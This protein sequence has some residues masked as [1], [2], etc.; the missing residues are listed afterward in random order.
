MLLATCWTALPGATSARAEDP[1]TLTAS[2]WITDRAHALGD[3][4]PEV[5][6]ALDRLHEDRLVQLFAV[7]VDDFSGR[8]A[9]NWADTTA[10]QNGL[11][12][13][14]VLL[15]VATGTRQYAYSVDQDFRL[16][17]QVLG[18]VARESAEPALR[19]GDWAGAAIGTAEGLDTALAEPGRRDGSVSASD[20]VLPVAV[21][22]AAGAVGAY[23]YAR[24]K[25]RSATRTT[26]A[27]TQGAGAQGAGRDGA[28]PQD[29]DA[30]EAEAD[31]TLVAT[32]DAIR[33]S[34]EELG[35][36]VAQ[37]GETATRPFA[38]AVAYAGSELATAFRLRQQL[39]DDPPPEGLALPEG[40]APPDEPELPEEGGE[41]RRRMLWE[42]ISRCAE[43]GRRLD[44]ESEAFDA[45]RALERDTPRALQA[46]E[47]AF[48]TLT[49][50]TAAADSTLTA[51]RQRYADSA[52]APVSGHV[53][54]AKEHLVSATASLNAAHQ[55]VDAEDRGEA[56]AQLRAAETAVTRATTLVDAVDRRAHELTAAVERLP[57]AVAATEALLTEAGATP[58][59]A[60]T[61]ATDTALPPPHPPSA[62]S[63]PAW[64]SRTRCRPRPSRPRRSCR[65]SRT[66]L[67]SAARASRSASASAPTRPASRAS[68]PS[69]TSRTRWT[70]APDVPASQSAGTDLDSEARTRL[71]G[72]LQ[73]A[74]TGGRTVVVGARVLDVDHDVAAAEGDLGGDGAAEIPAEAQIRLVTD[75]PQ[76]LD[77]VPLPAQLLVPGGPEALLRPGH[78]GTEGEHVDPWAGPRRTLLLRR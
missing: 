49:G 2:G 73:D 76:R 40:P 3:R 51:L 53:E 5:A 7:Y 59:G 32:D 11:G 48:R 20:Y 62:R 22:V 34:D 25:R 58:A 74:R 45:L 16:S 57:E 4:A 64:A 19:R 54:E 77:R 78:V 21:L 15:A 38:R 42:I 41:A 9:Q 8:T 60:P 29:L 30:L 6:A 1:V 46:V 70:T 12:R 71:R 69:T 17:D 24:R 43:A 13:D 28:A 61:A 44:A 56:A 52:T 67:G 10:Q 33:T 37:F 18:E 75:A 47:T 63:E 27:S 36:A 39:D 66:S 55:A 72:R 14:D 26:P 68:G 50:R 35:F 31:R 23:A 65:A